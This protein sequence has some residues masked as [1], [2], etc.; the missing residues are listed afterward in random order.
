MKASFIS[1]L[2]LCNHN[3]YEKKIIINKLFDIFDFVKV[4]LKGFGKRLI[5]VG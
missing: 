3:N 5:K 4:F 1:P 2:Y